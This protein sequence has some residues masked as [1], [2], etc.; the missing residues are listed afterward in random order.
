MKTFVPSRLSAVWV[1]LFLFLLFSMSLITN[2]MRLLIVYA[3]SSAA[4]SILKH[5]I[6]SLR[7]LFYRR[8]GNRRLYLL[9]STAFFNKY[10][11]RAVHMWVSER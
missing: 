11:A 4:R 5:P 7:S 3:I 10:L 6:Y 8:G 9:Y 1:S 2:K